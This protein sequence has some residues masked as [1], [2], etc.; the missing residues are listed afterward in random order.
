MRTTFFTC[1]NKNYED[2]IPIFIHSTLFHNDNSDIEI[3]VETLNYDVLKY[4]DVL[5]KIFVLSKLNIR[6]I[7]FNVIPNIA[8]FI[9]TPTIVND[10]VYITDIDIIVLQ[11]N[12]SQLHINDMNLTGL[13]YS[14]I[15][16]PY[17]NNSPKKLSG[18]HFTKW[19]SYYPIPDYDDLDLNDDEVFLYNLVGKKNVISECNTFRPVHGIH[20]SPNRKDPSS[21]LG[22]GLNRWKNEWLMYRNT[23][24]F[25]TL[26]SNCFSKRIN[27]NI[28]LIDEFYEKY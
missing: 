8:R 15:V 17:I 21:A 14:N 22:W 5:K 1:A 28:K 11:K 6:E 7:K 18:L 26:E 27:N 3:G 16:R 19:D 10:Y 4:I 12:I 23:E 24:D 20:M 13:N 2:F 9:D 25:K